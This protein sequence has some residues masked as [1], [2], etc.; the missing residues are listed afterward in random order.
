MRRRQ[1]DEVAADRDAMKRRAAV[2]A[3]AEVE[4]GMVL[5]LGSGTTAGFA[6]VA[7]A[8]RI[9]HGLRVVG[10]P[11]SQRTA[12]AAQRLGI[13][14][15]D[16]ATHRRLDLTIDGADEIERGTLALIKGLGGALLREKIIASASRRVIIIADDSKLVD[17][18]GA[19]VALPVEICAFG[20]AV[21][22]DRLA[23]CGA[24]PRLRQAGDAP[25]VTDGGNYI[26]DCRFA[27]MPEP[28]ALEA[29]LAAIVGVVESGLFIGLARRAII[30]D[31][32]GVTML[33][34]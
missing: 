25:F 4:S 16:L 11:T 8:A 1:A 21:T 34:A 22:L 18:L 29:R 27:T 26:A 12:E 31:A 10:V 20:A 9:T 3:V 5:G 14:L 2:A 19:R 23:E 24:V 7:L 15:G 32:A 33:D 6:L 13:P 17:R 30:G 28:A